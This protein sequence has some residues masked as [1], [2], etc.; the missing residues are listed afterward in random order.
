[1]G[2][3]IVALQALSILN[4]FEFK[5]KESADTYHKQIEA[6]KLAYAD[7]LKH[8]TESNDM[9]FKTGD[10]LCDE[11]AEKR[12]S[13]ITETACQPEA[14]EPYQSRTVYLATAD[15]EGNMVSFI[16]SN[17]LG[18]GSGIVVPDTGI[19]LQNRGHDFSLD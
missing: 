9:M 19:A 8:V 7:G 12:R 15:N 11:Y 5:E 10:I 14:G 6:I 17:Y 3:G 13:L 4:G 16:Q 2:Q 18:F 1:N